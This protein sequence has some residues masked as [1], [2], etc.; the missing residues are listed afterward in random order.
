[1]NRKLLWGV[2]VGMVLAGL[3][4]VLVSYLQPSFPATVLSVGERTYTPSRKLARGS[5]SSVYREQ[6]E[7]RY[8]DGET[9]TVTFSSTNPHALPK[10]GD[11]VRI[12]RWFS[13]MTTHP[14]RTLV[15]VGGG[16]AVIGGFFVVLFLLTKW[17]L[18]RD[19]ARNCRPPR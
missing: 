15:G 12:S 2:P 13:G 5:T 10:V 6:L 7:V 1:M 14:N 17:S 9:A 16:L 8:G 3:L 19:R 18:S 4:I 11:T